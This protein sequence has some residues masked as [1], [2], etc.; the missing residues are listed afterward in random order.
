MKRYLL[1]RVV[2]VKNRSCLRFTSAHLSTI[3]GNYVRPKSD[4]TTENAVFR[5]M[6]LFYRAQS[7]LNPCR[8]SI[9][10]TCE[11][12]YLRTLYISGY[13]HHLPEK[14]NQGECALPWSPAPKLVVRYETLFLMSS[15][16]SRYRMKYL[17]DNLSDRTY[18]FAIIV[19]RK[20][21]LIIL[22]ARI[23]KSYDT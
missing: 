22:T 9:P 13:S 3:T 5:C 16:T 21:I 10:V 14:L 4:V 6:V 17:V 15:S 1:C 2:F 19:E 8:R 12:C 20:A 7:C 11:R 18:K 23:F